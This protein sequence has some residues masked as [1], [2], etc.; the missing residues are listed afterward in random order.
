[1]IKKINN[2]DKQISNAIKSQKQKVRD[3]KKVGKQ[4]KVYDLIKDY[5]LE[6]IN[7]PKG[8]PTGICSKCGQKFEQDYCKD[9]NTYSNWPMCK[10][11]REKEIKNY[12]KLEKEDL[13]KGYN[14]LVGTIKYQPFPA[15][16]RIHEAFENHRFV[17]IA[18]GNRFG[19]DRCSMMMGIQY[20]ADCLSENRYIYNPDMVPSVMWWIV[21]PNEKFAMQNWRELKQYF[22]QNWILSRSDSSL[23]MQTLGGGLIEVRSGY[24]ENAL[25]GVGLD[26]VTVTEAA[27][28]RDLDVAWANLEARL[29]SP[30]RGRI[31]D[32]NNGRYGRGKAI[33]NSSPLGR[34]YFYNM[35]CWGQES[36]I[37]YDPDW[38]SCQCPWTDNPV[39]AESAAEIKHTKYGD[40]TK[41][42][43]MIRRMGERRYRENY[44]ADFLANDTTVFKE[45]ED[46]CVINIYS[47]ELGLSKEG[48]KDFVHQW[49]RVVP[50]RKYVGG[51]DPATG[52][53]EDNPWF[54]IRDT[55]TNNVV[56]SFNLYGKS[57]E[58]QADFIVMYCKMY[59]Y[60]KLNWLRTG[61]TALEGWFALR[62]IEENPL[63]E[64]G[65]HKAE[66]VQR[67]ETAVQNGDI[68]FLMDGS[69]D[70]QMLIYQMNDYTE[71]KTKQGNPQYAN[72][73]VPHDDCVSALYAAWAD[74]SVTD[75]PMAYFCLIGGV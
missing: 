72:K 60:A 24:D 2:H 25:R 13:Q 41:E 6:N 63:D 67:L 5:S 52:S 65:G 39:N 1:M 73:Q 59:N 40:L 4:P 48:R 7:S 30:G 14:N 17:V 42:Q 64:Q 54:V 71:T 3:A 75:M 35:F 27:V 46:K 69:E 26:L 66:L 68:H 8:S 50:G 43:R 33:I 53:S 56:R 16:Q 58:E 61:H 23:C 9:R 11:C 15:Q 32:R 47:P 10:E 36:H 57:Y 22:P 49:E 74:Y 20:F 62:G 55:E 45:F 34:N 44:M 38:W 70:A 37:D 28:F 51:Y 19:K 21:A 18:A 29:D 31:K 12:Q